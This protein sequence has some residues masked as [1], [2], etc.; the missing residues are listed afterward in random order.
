MVGDADFIF[1]VDG[2][3][4]KTAVTRR[5]K[6]YSND[7]IARVNGYIHTNCHGNLNQ[8]PSANCNRNCNA[9]GYRHARSHSHSPIDQHAAST[10]GR[11]QRHPPI[12][13]AALARRG[14]I[15]LL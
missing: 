12:Y 10:N 3:W 8:Y 15:Q 1:A 4:S 6:H 9:Y 7:Y 11:S 13:R 2:L 14:R 5:T